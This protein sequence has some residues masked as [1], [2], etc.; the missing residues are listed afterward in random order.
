MHRLRSQATHP[1]QRREEAAKMALTLQYSMTVFV[2]AMLIVQAAGFPRGARDAVNMHTAQRLKRQS[3]DDGVQS[4]IAGFTYTKLML[5]S[6]RE[7]TIL[8]DVSGINKTNCSPRP[9]IN[10]AYTSLIAALDKV[11]RL[12]AFQKKFLDGD[13]Q[14]MSVEMRA[15]QIVMDTLVNQTCTWVSSRLHVVLYCMHVHVSLLI[16]LL[17]ISVLDA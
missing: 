4:L 11:L 9:G 10:S 17:H 2:G 3:S 8:P 15:L 12:Y 7:P 14:N 5:L 1:A 16:G 6:C 13:R